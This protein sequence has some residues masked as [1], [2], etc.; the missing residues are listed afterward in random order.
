MGHIRVSPSPPCQLAVCQRCRQTHLSLILNGSLCTSNPTSMPPHCSCKMGEGMQHA[1][2]TSTTSSLCEANHQ[3]HPVF[4]PLH[5]SP[6]FFLR[7]TFHSIT[8][9]PACTHTENVATVVSRPKFSTLSDEQER[10]RIQLKHNLRNKDLSINLLSFQGDYSVERTR[11][12]ERPRS[13]FSYRSFGHHNPLAD[14]QSQINP[15]S[16]HT[17]GKGALTQGI[18]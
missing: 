3:P 1:L 2:T 18:H 13:L 14:D 15:W 7:N 17:G 4:P 6:L 12:S 11:H 10:H 16:Y 5:I 9:P 8:H